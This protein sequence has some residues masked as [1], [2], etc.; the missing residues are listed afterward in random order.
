MSAH[1]F[2]RLN[3]TSISEHHRRGILAAFL[4]ISAIGFADAVYLTI[5]FLTNSPIACGRFGG[6]DA[7]AGSGY[8]T[9]FGAP[10]AML[11]AMY[12]LL[13][14]VL[15]L[16]YLDTKKMLF[17]TLAA[18]LTPIGFLASIYFVSLQLFVINAICV[19]CMVSAG[20]STALFLIGIFVGYKAIGGGSVR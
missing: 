10:V 13:V 6:C 8:A 1:F 16:L 5:T 20:T 14:L 12:Y 11:G 19:Y 4:C 17:L 9:I 15:S 3:N 7:V 2:H 18:L